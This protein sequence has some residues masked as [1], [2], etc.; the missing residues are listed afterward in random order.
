MNGM[1]YLQRGTQINALK[2]AC[3]LDI[4]PGKVPGNRC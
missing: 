4:K 1:H 2:L 3:A